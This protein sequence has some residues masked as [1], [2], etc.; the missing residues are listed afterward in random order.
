[1]STAVQAAP[2]ARRES[3]PASAARIVTDGKFLRS[4]DDRFLVK[5]VT[6]GTFAPDANGHQFPPAGQ[7][8]DDFRLMAQLGI[9]TVRVYTPPSVEL[10][11][12]AARRGLRV[13]VGVPW[14]QHVAFLDDGK[15]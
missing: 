12:E 7:V 6:Y 5:G 14:S 4:G 3:A 1:M 2:E 15:L 10:L 9:N 8:A 13:M 11:D